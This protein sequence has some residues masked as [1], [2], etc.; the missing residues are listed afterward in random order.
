MLS[1]EEEKRLPRS[2]ERAAC[3]SNTGEL[4]HGITEDFEVV[5]LDNLRT[6]NDR[7]KLRQTIDW[8][9]G[10]CQTVQCS[11]RAERKNLPCFKLR[12]IIF[13]QNKK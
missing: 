6:A 10:H 1:R 11:S 7:D 13:Q 3:K 8:V 12:D 5:D 2:L 9:S 4:C